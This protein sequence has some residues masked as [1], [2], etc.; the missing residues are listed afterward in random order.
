MPIAPRVTTTPFTPASLGPALIEWWSGDVG[1]FQG[2][3]NTW[4]GYNGIVLTSTGNQRPTY[5]KGAIGATGTGGGWLFNGTTNFMISVSNFPA[6]FNPFDIFVGFVQTAGNTKG[7]QGTLVNQLNSNIVNYGSIIQLQNSNGLFAQATGVEV[8]TTPNVYQYVELQ[9]NSAN[10]FMG[11]N[12]IQ[13]SA[14]NQ[15]NNTTNT[16]GLRV[17][18]NSNVPQ[19]LFQGTIYEIAFFNRIL[20]AGERIFLNA[21][22]AAGPH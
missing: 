9:V 10:S 3:N 16:S 15:T 11:L 12:G 2:T 22:F 14:F 4:T 20:S 7:S 21:Y 19:N 13:S 17:G 8:T 1:I 18:A 6:L 5:V